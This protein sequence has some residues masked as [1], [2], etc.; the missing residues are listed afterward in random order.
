MESKSDFAMQDNSL[1][2]NTQIKETKTIKTHISYIYI[3]T[4]LIL[5]LDLIIYI[6][7]I[8]PS[9][10]QLI[11]YPQ[12]VNIYSRIKPS[13][14]KILYIIVPYFKCSFFG[15]FYNPMQS[16]LSFISGSSCCSF[17]A[18][19]CYNPNWFN[20]YRLHGR[21]GGKQ[22]MSLQPVYKQATLRQASQ[23]STSYTVLWFRGADSFRA[24]NIN[25]KMYLIVN[26]T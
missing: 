3:Y 18:L 25:L 1:H 16:L 20:W 12:E 10:Y 5:H 22:T 4:F 24:D 14:F 6:L 19:Y 17:T 15:T 23:L 2:S 8:Y 11:L 9:I 7:S 21:S 26:N 13:C